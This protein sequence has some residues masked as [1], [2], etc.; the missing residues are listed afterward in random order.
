M[1]ALIQRVSQASV[2]VD[3]ERVA[4]IQQGILALIGIEKE[5]SPELADRLL[6]KILSYRIFSDEEGKM[7]LGLKDIQG[8]LL[9]VSQFTLAADTKKG[10]R[11]S[12]SSAAK[13]EYAE[14]LY[15]YLLNIAQNLH[16]GTQSG[17][18]AAD[19]KVSLCNDGPVTFLLE[20]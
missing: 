4:D 8:E 17:I 12:F 2:D 11:P 20:V 7:N 19:M 14:E 1:K 6:Q 9:L 13:P 16:P 10:Q 18:F 5:D 3:G 15:N